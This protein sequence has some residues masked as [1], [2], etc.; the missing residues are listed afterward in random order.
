MKKLSIFLILFF[1]S[2]TLY[3]QDETASTADT[4]RKD[5]INVYM[6]AP[7]YIRKEVP[8]INYVRDKE[9]A[10]LIIIDTQ[11]RTGSGGTEITFFIEGQN[12]FEGAKDTIKFT[13]S[14]DDTEDQIRLKAVRLLKMG[15]MKYII[16]TPLAEFIDISFSQ[17]ISEE[18]S[19]DKWNNWIFRT[20]ISGSLNGRETSKSSSVSS[21]LSAGKVTSDWKL[22]FGLNYS[23]SRTVY[24]YGDISATNTRK[25]SRVWG[26]AV[27]SLSDHWSVGLS[28]DAFNSIYSN[29]DFGISMEPAI[30]YD[31]FPYSEST[32]RIFRIFYIV[33]IRYNN[34]SDTTQFFKTE[35]T[36]WSHRFQT[37]FTTVQKWGDINISARWSNYLHDF[38]LNNLSLNADIDIKVTKGLSLNLRANYAFIHDQISLRKEMLQLKMFFLTDRSYQP[39]TLTGPA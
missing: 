8:F 22:N 2:F 30:E 37:S 28:T 12:K 4:L 34:Y 5:A 24:D 14:P 16:E 10:D 25:S 26:D 18:V 38:S 27:K 3:S 6:D 33:G 23:D 7:S 39:P 1:C 20:R 19:T 21:S 31:I 13:I 9:D 11:Q 17:R 35:E 32:R 36:L 29:Y 15:L